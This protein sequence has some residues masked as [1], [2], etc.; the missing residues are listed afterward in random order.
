ME[1]S[2]NKLTNDLLELLRLYSEEEVRFF[3]NLIHQ[4][5]VIVFD[6]QN[7]VIFS[8]DGSDGK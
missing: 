3:Q 8:E 6:Y 1:K 5:D 4:T 7:S 2:D